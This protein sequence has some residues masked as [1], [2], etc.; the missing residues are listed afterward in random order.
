MEEADASS[1]HGP[2]A[3]A[4]QGVEALRLLS[5]GEELTAG[6][7]GL[8]LAWPGWGA[9]APAFGG[10]PEGSWLTIAR[11][12]EDLL[13]PEEM[14]SAKDQTDT[15]FFTPRPVTDA[16]FALL[17]ASGFRGGK[18]L[19]PG[20]GSG[21][22]MSAAP[23]GFEID[24][25]GVE[26][27]QTSARIAS[28]LNP[29]ARIINA[30]L[31][32]IAFVSGEFDA[33][34]GNVPFSSSGVF[35]PEYKN[36]LS[37]HEYF[38]R[39][40]LDAVR[41]GGYVI[42]V[43][44]RFTMDG[45]SMGA[46]LAEEQA[47]LIAA[48]RLPSG[49]FAD[50]GT[51]TVTDIVAFRKDVVDEDLDTWDDEWQN[52]STGGYYGTSN[53]LTITEP[54]KPGTHAAA[55][56][57]N[58]YW[59]Q[60]PSHVAGT[61]KVSSYA[62]NPLVV[63]SDSAEV[64]I[65]RAVAAATTRII[66]QTERVESD[67]SAELAGIPLVDADGRK[68]GSFHIVDDTI[69][70]VTAGRLI[71][72]RN[73][74]E[75]RALI[76]LRDAAAKLI[77]LEADNQLSDAA[78]APAREHAHQ[79]YTA[80][81]TKFGALNRGTLAEGKP[82]PESGDPTY[83]WR[84]PS[85]GG[86][87]RDPD[88]V[89]VMALEDFDQDD[90][91][92]QPAPILLRRVNHAPV[93]VTH[94]DTAA[95]ALSISVGEGRGVD[96]ERISSLLDLDDQQKT[97]QALGDL[98]FIDQGVPVS[99]RDYL[100]G[101]VRVK[102]AT[103]RKQAETDS[104]YK[105]NVTALEQVLPKDLGP[106]EIRAKLGSP[107][108]E[109][110]D[111]DD[112]AREVLGTYARAEY[113]A[114]VGLWEVSDN[115]G[116]YT[117]AMTEFGT[118]RMPA[119]KLL[120]HALNGT[121]AVVYDERYEFGRTVRTRNVAETIAAEEKLA[122]LDDR[123]S[124]WIWEDGDRSKRLCAEYNRRFN[125]YV[126]RTPDGS[127]L[128]FPGLAEAVNPWA[129]Q[130]NAVDLI[131]SSPRALIGHPVGAGK[132][133][134]MILSAMTLRRFGL[135]RKPLI[136]VPNHLLDQIIREAQQAFPTGRFLIASKD[137]LTKERRRL[138]AARCATGDWD[139]VV[140]THQAFT[141]L[142]VAPETEQ[143]WIQE[144]KAEL[145]QAMLTGTTE[146][147]SRGAKA[148]ARGVRA[149]EARIEKLR[150]GVQDEDQVLFDHLGIDYIMVD[151]A[152]LFR[153]LSTGSATRDSGFSSGSS[154][155]ALD[156]QLKIETLADKHPGKPILAMFTGT[157][158]SNS[159]AETWV[160][161]T[162]TQPE[163][164]EAAG[165]R[166]FEP[167]V[168]TFV[169][170]ETAVEVAPDGSGFRMKRRP[171]GVKNL[172]ELKSMLRQVADIVSPESIGLE[173][174]E[175]TI[176]QVVSEPTPEQKEFVREL[177]DRADQIHRGIHGKLESR[178]GRQID[179]SMLLICGDGRKVALDP[180]L[181]GIAEQSSKLDDAA[182]GIAKIYHE[183][184]NDPYGRSGKLGAL[185]LVLMDLGTPKP[186]DSNSYGRLRSILVRHGVPAER[187]R[188]IHEAKTD[189]ARP[190]LFAQCREGEVSVLIGSTP[191]VGIGTNIQ[192]RLKAL[193]HIDVPWMPAEVIQREGRAL[194]PGNLNKHIDIYRCVTEG[195]FDA[196]TWAAVERK[197]RS[198]YRLY[199][200]DPNIR[201]IDDIS[202]VAL[203]YGEMK[204]LA[205]GNPLLLEQAKYAHE[206]QRLRLIR[207]VFLQDVNRERRYAQDQDR[208]AES[209]L[210]LAADIESALESL[211]EFSQ[212]DS[213]TIESAA[214]DILNGALRSFNLPYRGLG[215]RFKRQPIG[216]TTETVAHVSHRYREITEIIIPKSVI[217]DGADH[218]AN[219]LHREL[220]TLTDT[221]MPAQVIGDRARAEECR[222]GSQKAQAHA[223]SLIFDHQSEL[224]NAIAALARI[225]SLIESEAT[226][227][228]PVAA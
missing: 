28:V 96:L 147:R 171:V 205:A 114:A 2:V 90:G 76:G 71:P 145:R 32:R 8:L 227:Q 109:P 106:L 189:K 49:A 56:E 92:A 98:V 121:A 199:D 198:F 55:T 202:E 129:H 51:E 161:Q 37:L 77:A 137:D 27:D 188:F 68:E 25:T 45:R 82:D 175:F 111:V 67:L 52:R 213:Q 74:A 181:V 13:T 177:A 99:A 135:A 79:L 151:E 15:S 105:R 203:G 178:D 139:A 228:M 201:E 84:R 143:R 112:F 155:R 38:I 165:V 75:L 97:L 185:Q 126:A 63:V 187:I 91:E 156:L 134:S 100:S 123:F 182:A 4:K 206:V 81:L 179:D 170:Y 192:T 108:I 195:T 30:P 174:P 159:L 35:T 21:R 80:Y 211:S 116:G 125:S 217:R 95:E 184:K 152:H 83:T 19:E 34:V 29:S 87:R 50:E 191:K 72:V 163:A 102:L 60:F 158:W 43:T 122:A 142:P 150:H 47:S 104:A 61:M 70:E 136:T 132:T 164:L 53:R 6:G 59:G 54:L 219:F 169:T 17:G 66:S 141:S 31:Q 149:L 113:T 210:R 166:V 40:S 93:P 176:H 16:V 23:A 131:V 39:R 65:V 200:D 33:A 124:T 10:N 22:F 222:D 138:F 48:V 5:S 186:G 208:R 103:A 119:G 20:C 212:R 167:W 154:K 73:N 194:R 57:V 157:P 127:H 94:A 183:T 85:L 115:G 62:Q 107:W 89:L 148:I 221:W 130:K 225:D 69:V 64:D 216:R 18:V 140:M 204:A 58:A 220:A 110:K 180:H 11:D 162:Y 224:D 117:T 133:L 44:S 209:L 207:S 24:W 41:P 46:M 172:P 120:G 26:I 193:W 226:E 3:R 1:V 197:E 36:Y 146:P 86:F 14:T 214:S 215:L 7:R 153:R 118:T 42:L 12:L 78:I 223:D 168:S 144:R 101:N 160:W 173:R 9:F 88:Y 128:S 196:F 190:A 218:T